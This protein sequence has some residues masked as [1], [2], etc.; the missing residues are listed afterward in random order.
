MSVDLSAQAF[1]QYSL[2]YYGVD[3]NKNA[4][5]SLQD[6][7]GLNVNLALAVLFLSHYSIK[8]E[9]AFCEHMYAQID[10]LDELTKTQRQK[11]RSLLAS[12]ISEASACGQSKSELIEQVKLSESYKQALQCELDLEKQQQLGLALCFEQLSQNQSTVSLEALNDLLISLV[13]VFINKNLDCPNVSSG[14]GAKMDAKIAESLKQH[15]TTLVDN[16]WFFDD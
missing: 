13:Y 10:A 8:L 12:G 5:L 11:R 16:F 4:L 15:I 1:W 3:D 14:V 7:F 2:A 6:E 9:L